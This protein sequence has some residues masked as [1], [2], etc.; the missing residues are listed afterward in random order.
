LNSDGWAPRR[1]LQRDTFK[2]DV[3]DNEKEYVID[4]ELPGVDK[5][6]IKVELNEGR[7]TISIDR[8]ENIDEEN[9]NYIHK[10][11]RYCSMCRGIYLADADQKGVKAKL[12]NGIL[13]ITVPK[14][15]KEDSIIKVDIE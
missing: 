10:E 14:V 15:L 2:I 9:K 1:S 8:E 5:D 4:A 12:D 3:Q 11:R 7:L 13:R 6:E